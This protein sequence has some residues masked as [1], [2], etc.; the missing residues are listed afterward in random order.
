[1]GYNAGAEI[2][3]LHVLNDVLLARAPELRRLPDGYARVQLLAE[4][5]IKRLVF[6]AHDRSYIVYGELSADFPLCMDF[7][8]ICA[9]DVLRQS[10]RSGLAVRPAF[11]TLAYTRKQ[12]PRHAINWAV[13]ADRRVLF[14]EPQA[15][16]W[17]DQPK[18][19]TTLDEFRL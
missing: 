1:M 4:C 9:G 10:I 6:D 12:G 13:T 19:A 8:A 5:D 14:L 11:G 3:P 2:V 15:D 17:L 7:A 18:D 16:Q